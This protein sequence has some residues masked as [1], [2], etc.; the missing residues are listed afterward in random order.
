MRHEARHVRILGCRGI[1]A[2][3]GGFETFCERFALYL[4]ERGY[5]VTVYCQ[6]DGEGATYEDEWHGV[7]RVHIGARGDGPVSTIVFD[8]RAMRHA[9][10]ESGVALVLGYGTG[11]FLGLHKLFGIPT[12]INMD[13]LEAQRDKYHFVAR[14]WLRLCEWVACLA[15]DRVIAD[16]PLIGAHLSRFQWVTPKLRMIPYGASPRVADLSAL[17]AIGVERNQYYLV[18]ARPEIDNQIAE[19]VEAYAAEPRQSKLVILGNYGEGCSDYAREVRANA[20]STVLFPGA[21]YEQCVVHALREH[22]RAYVHGHTVGG[23]NPSLLESLVAGAPVVAHDN[24]F[25]RWVAGRGAAYFEDAAKLCERF[26]EF[27]KRTNEELDPFRSCS[28]GRF[29]EAFG[30]PDVLEAYEHAI[31]ELFELERPRLLRGSTPA[32]FRSVPAVADLSSRRV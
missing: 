20:P 7:R 26:S 31:L 23:T 11:V 13:G 1:P 22:C 2:R 15:A 32:A 25:N 19:I 30:W 6:Q 29:L 8:W 4:I 24:G 3:H 14:T 5:R 12:G 9:V 16:H 28:R 21:I 27:D 18:V 10:R 17:D